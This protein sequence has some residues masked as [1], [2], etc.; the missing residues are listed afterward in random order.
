MEG[1]GNWVKV[2]KPEVKMSFTYES[3]HATDGFMGV[4]R[5]SSLRIRGLNVKF[6]GRSR[7]T[8]R[9]GSSEKS[10]DHEILPVT[11]TDLLPIEPKRSQVIVGFHTVPLFIIP[12]S[13]VNPSVYP[14]E[15]PDKWRE[16]DVIIM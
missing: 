16:T 13:T 9:I 14:G 6:R 11:S 4:D 8:K 5:Y 12:V 7:Q 2:L 10:K 1:R 15:G 3:L